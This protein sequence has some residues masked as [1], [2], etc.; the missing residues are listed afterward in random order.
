MRRKEPVTVR[1]VQKTIVYVMLIDVVYF[2]EALEKVGS[3]LAHLILRVLP[4]NDVLGF[5][6]IAN[7]PRFI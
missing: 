3:K 6:H 2:S 7:Q 4:Q 1:L 5:H